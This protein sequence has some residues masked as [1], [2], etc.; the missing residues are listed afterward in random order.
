MAELATIK[1]ADDRFRRGF[2]LI[3]A[4]DF[5]EEVHT[6]YEAEA[7]GEEPDATDAAAELADEANLDLSTIEGTGKNG[8]I[9]K[10]DV[11]DAL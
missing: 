9:L 8:R 2:R 3:N 6:R 5:D 10:S 1:V 4:E 11:T 7:P